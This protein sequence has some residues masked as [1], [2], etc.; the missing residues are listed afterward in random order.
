MLQKKVSCEVHKFG[1]SSLSNAERFI[2][3]RS[4]LNQNNQIIIV[5]AVKGTTSI[6]QDMIDKASQG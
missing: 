3:V 6:L 4:I 2:A 1:G 5:S